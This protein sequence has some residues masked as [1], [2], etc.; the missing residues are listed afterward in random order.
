VLVADD[1]EQSAVQ[2]NGRVE[3]RRDAARLMARREA[4]GARITLDV[5]GGDDA[6]LLQCGEVGR[7]VL[8]RELGGGV[9]AVADG[10]DADGMR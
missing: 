5:V 9:G 3:R 10:V 1:A 2:A 8:D 6:L 4:R 7:I